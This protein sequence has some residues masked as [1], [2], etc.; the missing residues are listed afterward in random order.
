MGPDLSRERIALILAALGTSA[1]IT[2]CAKGAEPAAVRSDQAPTAS[3]Q[4]AVAPPPPPEATPTGAP[5]QQAE[6]KG[7]A[8]DL[9]NAAPSASAPNPTQHSLGRRPAG[10]TGQTGQ[11]SCGAGTCTADMKKK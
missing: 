2:A 10:G 7:K 4:S 3:A 9:G 8:A 1:V 11:A 6:E 5:G